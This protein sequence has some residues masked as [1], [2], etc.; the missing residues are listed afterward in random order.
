MR[1]DRFQLGAVVRVKNPRIGV[2]K[3]VSDEIGPIGEY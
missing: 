3:K 1:R 2:V